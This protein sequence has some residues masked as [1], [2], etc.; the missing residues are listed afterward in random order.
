MGVNSGFLEALLP[1]EFT[2]RAMLAVV[3]FQNATHFADFTPKAMP[4]AVGVSKHIVFCLAKPLRRST[5]HMQAAVAFQ[6]IAACLLLIYKILSI[7]GF[8][9]SIIATA[10]FIT[11]Y[12]GSE[13]V[14]PYHREV[15]VQ[16]P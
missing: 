1:A 3:G 9:K 10:N 2:P 4:A 11:P 5:P 8:Y 12:A 16:S 15:S 6:V 14:C 13:K 7:I